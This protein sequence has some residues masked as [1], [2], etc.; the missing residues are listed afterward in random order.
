MSNTVISYYPG[1]GGHRYKNVLL[2]RYNNIPGQ[3]YDTGVDKFN[4]RYITDDNLELTCDNEILL[5]HCLNIDLIKSKIPN[6]NCIQIKS[7]LHTSLRRAWGKFFINLRRSHFTSDLDS[8]YTTIVWHHEYYKKYPK[9]DN[10]TIVHIDGDDIFSK[11]MQQEL[12][13]EN[14]IFD[15]AW[16]VYTQYGDNAPIIDI[17]RETNTNFSKYNEQK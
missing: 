13:Y 16:Q 4:I 8:A 6:C 17:E 9:T 12:Q 1:A 2:G 10:A 14:E 3:I 15:T 7:D 5:T 11:M